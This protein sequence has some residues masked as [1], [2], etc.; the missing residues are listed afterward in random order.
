M[1]LRLCSRAPLT[2]IFFMFL[3]FVSLGIVWLAR[4]VA[5]APCWGVPHAMN[6]HSSD[7]TLP[8]PDTS[9][10]AA[11]LDRAASLHLVAR[12]RFLAREEGVRA[13]VSAPI[14]TAIQRDGAA[15]CTARS[16]AARKLSA[17]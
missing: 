4:P 17:R 5:S 8:H 7:D 12:V 6:R 14:A 15:M 11:F 13:S 1:F 9:R 10:T 2:T 16:S 3:S